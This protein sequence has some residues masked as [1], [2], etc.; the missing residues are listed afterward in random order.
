MKQRNLRKKKKNANVEQQKINL[1]LLQGYKPGEYIVCDLKHMPESIDGHV[2]LCVFTCVGTR[3]SE[4]YFLKTRLASEFLECYVKYCKFIRNKTG[5]YPKVLHTDN[6]KEFIDKCTSTFNKKKGITHTFTSPHSSLQNPIAERINRTIGEG[7]LAFLLCAYLPL[8][9]WTFAVT[10]FL[11]VKMRTP[12]K[13]LNLSTPIASWNIHNSYRSTVDL[14]DIRIFGCEAYVLDENSLK[15]HPKA[16]RCI[17]LGPSNSQKGCMFYNLHTKKIICSRNF[18]LNE[19]CMPGKSYFPNIY[20]R[21][22]GPTPPTELSEA[23]IPV[24]SPNST[25][26]NHNIPYSN[27]FEFSNNSVDDDDEKNNVDVNN[28]NNNNNNNN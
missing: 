24:F 11:F 27:L 4:T 7:A 28:N 26:D 3:Y 20:D 8:T 12:H 13:S 10:N 21:Y 18:V 19:Q 6:G 15:A 23:D 22:F 2:Y 25:L 14:F 5:R 1:S 9:F 16:F 17:Y